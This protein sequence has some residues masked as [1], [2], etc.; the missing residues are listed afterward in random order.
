[1]LD[2]YLQKHEN[3]QN[4]VELKNATNRHIGMN[5]KNAYLESTTLS[6]FKTI[7]LPYI[8]KLVLSY[9]KCF[10]SVIFSRMFNRHKGFRRTQ[11]KTH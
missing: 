2:V 10:F 4:I 3:L 8:K 9:D 7:L 11:G 1:M 6:Y 5:K